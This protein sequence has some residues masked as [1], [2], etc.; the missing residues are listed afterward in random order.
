[1]VPLLQPTLVRLWSTGSCDSV[2]ADPH[3]D[4]FTEAGDRNIG[5]WC[6]NYTLYRLSHHMICRVL[7]KRTVECLVKNSCVFLEKRRKMGKNCFLF[8][9]IFCRYDKL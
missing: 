5:H 8:W 4:S 9:N 2:R 1:M 3:T 6:V 7:G